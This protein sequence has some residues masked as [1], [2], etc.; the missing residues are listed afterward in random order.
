MNCYVHTV[1]SMLN[2]IRSLKFESKAIDAIIVLDVF[3]EKEYLTKF[4]FVDKMFVIICKTESH[5]PENKSKD[6]QMRCIQL[7][8]FSITHHLL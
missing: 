4:I 2:L 1:K 7:W 5:M 8:V 6:K 3:I